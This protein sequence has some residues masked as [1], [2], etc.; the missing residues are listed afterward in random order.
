MTTISGSRVTP[1]MRIF[2]LAADGYRQVFARSA[3][4]PLLSR[5][6][7]VRRTGYDIPVAV[8]RVRAE[9]SDV[10]SFEL[11]PESGNPVP[12]WS[13]GAHLD[14]FLPSG[15]QRSYSLCGDPEDRT[16]F[17]IAVRRIPVEAGGEG[18]SME[19]HA[20]SAGDRLTVRGPRN[21]FP[22]RQ[23][24]N[25][26]F[27]AG[28]IGITPILPMVRH[29]E[30]EGA[31][32]KLVFLG[33]SRDSLPFLDELS[34]ID[35]GRGR[36][37]VRTDDALGPPYIPDVLAG[38]DAGSAVYMCGPPSLMDTAR[39]VLPDLDPAATLHTERFS[40]PEIVGGTAFTLLVA[41]SNE[42]VQVAANETTLDAIRRVAPGVSYSCRQ[43]F[44]SSCMTRVI[45]G[46]VDHRDHRLTESERS[47]YM[48]TCVSRAAGPTLTVELNSEGRVQP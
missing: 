10:V 4:A 42:K 38:A 23:T 44:C 15:A 21:A 6:R 22:F 43:G 11:T 8:T 31:N 48:L 14:V 19:M 30:R 12:R 24:S 40:P 26:F 34:A 2:G 27:I 45:A 29:A 17:R 13:P 37:D 36:V 46:E 1:A 35:A 47:E 3:L 20:L 25:Y 41:G 9:A 28:G 16:H 7:P 18:G 39:M 33:R 32:W 5:P